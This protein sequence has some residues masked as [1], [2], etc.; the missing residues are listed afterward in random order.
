MSESKYTAYNLYNK[1]NIKKTYNLLTE[2]PMRVVFV[3][4][5]FLV[6]RLSSV[7]SAAGDLIVGREVA[8]AVLK[9]L[10]SQRTDS[11]QPVV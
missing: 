9:R 2:E 1:T 4:N 8:K 3:S 5:E 11:C 6:Q 7:S 10:I